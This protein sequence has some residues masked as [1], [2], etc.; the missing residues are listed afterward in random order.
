MSLRF[1][2]AKAAGAVSTWGLRHV[3]HR[4]AA[5]L[6]GKIALAIDPDLLDEL[7]GKCRQGSVI[8]VGTNGKTSTNNLLADAFEVAGRTIICNRT[9]ANL[10]AGITSALLQQPAA[11]W[12]VFECDELWLAHVP[13]SYTHL[14][15]YKRQWRLSAL[16]CGWCSF[17]VA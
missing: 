6:P 4:P 3:A 13:V 9:G 12:G 7:R 1:S 8:T 5:N 15:V 17:P 11:Q 14:D 2:L 16:L 10:A